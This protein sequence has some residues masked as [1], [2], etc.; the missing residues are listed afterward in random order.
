MNTITYTLFKVL[1]INFSL[2]I[3]T[4][5]TYKEIL[6]ISIYTNMFASEWQKKKK[7]KNKMKS[8]KRKVGNSV[9]MPRRKMI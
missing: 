9:Q 2:S 3:L 7:Y 6:T 1:A 8:K 5:I 4:A